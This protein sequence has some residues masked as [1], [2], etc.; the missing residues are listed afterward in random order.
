[1][2]EQELVAMQQE[3]VD[4]V[5][6]EKRMKEH[7]VFNKRMALLTSIYAVVLALA[8]LG[9][10]HYT[11]SLI[12][13]NQCASDQW[14]HFQSKSIKQ[15]MDSNSILIIKD[16]NTDLSM[17]GKAIKELNADIARYD[18]EKK[19]ISVAARNFEHL[20]EVA[21]E[22]VEKF[23]YAQTALQ[24]AIILTSVSILANAL[25]SSIVGGFCAAVG[26]FLTLKGFL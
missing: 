22:K 21:K 4:L 24:L 20:V 3:V 2:D 25:Y 13:S 17:K 9:A 23:E 7:D 5:V 14:S 10:D 26:L 1:M 15:H 19:E 11:K 18:S 8:S 6:E 16:T 12:V